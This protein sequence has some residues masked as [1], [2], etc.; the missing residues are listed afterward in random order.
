MKK[1]GRMIQTR[2]LKA[3]VRSISNKI[4]HTGKLYEVVNEART[5]F[6]LAEGWRVVALQVFFFLLRLLISKFSRCVVGVMRPFLSQVLTGRTRKS[7]TEAGPALS[8]L[9]GHAS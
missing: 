4:K 9:P 2:K 5:P 1:K 3:I 6:F 8:Y 7:C